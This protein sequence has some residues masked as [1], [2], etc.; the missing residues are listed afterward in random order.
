MRT[1]S[2]VLTLTLAQAAPSPPVAPPAREIAK[3]TYL[4]PGAMLPDRGPDGN[5]VMMVGPSGLIVVDTG[6]HPWHSDAII[7]FA[8]SQRLPVVAI[9]NTHWH[10][11]H[12]SGNRR[13]KAAYPEARVYTT[14][15]VDRTLVPGG[16]LVRNLAAARERAADPKTSAV[17]QEETA[18]FLATME[19]SDGLR[20]DVPVEKSGPITLAGRPVSARVEADAVTDAD[21]WLY[22]EATRIAVIGDLVTL[23]APF[24]ETA[25]PARWQTALDAVW[26][27]PF[28]IAVPGHGAVMSRA[29]F[30]SYR[31]AFGG[32]R[33]CVASDRTAAECS[34]DWTRDV[35]PLLA[36]DD[37][38]KQAREYAAYYVDF[39]RKG[40]GASPDC[41]A[42]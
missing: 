12:S 36:T 38:R 11:D 3:D 29:E 39:L 17:R 6:R 30:D 4:L 20:A 27:T 2:L 9:V 28:T 15:A 21:L 13:I 34:V 22:D 8:Q 16:F 32:F 14:R 5:T 1:L 10:L 41:R 42:R 25:C 7:A 23:P 31:Q 26:A 19:N 18:L 40:G 24:F 37:D 33:A 35:G